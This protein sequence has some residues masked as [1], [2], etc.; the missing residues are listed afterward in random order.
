MCEKENIDIKP[1]LSLWIFGF[2][3]LIVIGISVIVCGYFQV[4]G[5]VG[6]EKANWGTFGDYV[7]GLSNP[8]LSFFGLIAILYTVKMQRDELN[9]SKKE[10]ELTRKELERSA[11]AQENTERVMKE[12]VKTQIKQQFESTFFALLN[13]HNAV[14]D[15][16]SK[17]SNRIG[18]ESDLQVILN[19]IK[20]LWGHA[21]AQSD[22]G[23][24]ADI[25]GAIEY[26]NNLCGHYFR[27]LYQI[28]K[29]VRIANSSNGLVA[30]FDSGFIVSQPVDKDEKFYT[31]I[32]RAFL[33]SDVTK[34]LAFYCCCVSDD[35]DHWRFKL[36]IERYEFLEHLPRD[37]EGFKS[38]VMKFYLPSAFGKDVGPEA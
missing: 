18:G 8:F 32:V 28:L 15:G 19:D 5:S 36:L 9:L 1:N 34:L 21:C 29:F 31:N 23:F 35:D 24:V 10:L 16:L 17:S 2:V 12:Q 26:R 38:R 7:G 14:L 27:I 37:D 20:N 30:V 11:S 22:D 25:R 3:G 6:V 4:F 13:Q 33:N